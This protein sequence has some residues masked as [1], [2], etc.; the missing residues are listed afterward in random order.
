MTEPADIAPQIADWDDAYA[1]GPYIPHSE[2]YPERW[3]S[4]A[5]LFRQSLGDRA[6][7]DVTYGSHPRERL[8]LFHPEGPAAGLVVFVHG[9][10]WKAF[11]KSYWSHLAAGSL[12]RGWA[13]ALPG[14][15]LAPD[16]TISGIGR[17]VASAIEALSER[18]D[19]PLALTGHSAG[20]QLVTRAL[21]GD[22][23]LSKAT[24]AKVSAVVSISGVHD[25]R[26]LLLTSM[27]D[28]LGLTTDE[29]LAESPALAAP[30]DGPTMSCWVGA[31]ERPEFIRQ[32]EL[33]ADA[34]SSDE[35]P[36][37]VHVEP[38]RHHFD[39]IDLLIDPES[40]LVSE[41]T[42]GGG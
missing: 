35:R 42:A 7:L 31:E 27:N 25:L 5:A 19:R 33:L 14:Y 17:Q 18:F 21:A 26:P 37:A 36:V 23:L 30:L 9:G 28:T 39:V 4:T 1:N 16:A 22:G 3:A 32:S 34:W 6:D 24:V 2:E 40:E 29:A 38:G 8:D 10:Y 20:G 11:D 41:L 15:V 12:Q 13:V